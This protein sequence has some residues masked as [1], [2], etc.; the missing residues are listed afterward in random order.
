MSNF[1]INLW[2]FVQAVIAIAIF[3]WGAAR[4]SGT[5][6]SIALAAI[7]LFFLTKL[8][9]ARQFVPFAVAYAVFFPALAGVIFRSRQG[10]MRRSLLITGIICALVVM[11]WFKYPYYSSLLFGDWAF[12]GK[13]SAIDWLGLSYMTFR[14]LDL[15]IHAAQ[16]RT[17]QLNFMQAVSY[18]LFFT[19][20]LA[21]P[22]N[23]YGS[24]VKDSG[25]ELEPI[26]P[27]FL[28]AGVMRACIGIIKIIVVGRF[29]FHY[30]FLGQDID[31]QTVSPADLAIATYCTFLYI[32]VDFSGYC[33]V[34]IVLGR[35]FGIQI[36]E[37][38]NFPFLARN[39]QEFWNRWHISLSHWCRDH[40]FFNL[41]RL[42]AVRLPMLPDL[43]SL[44]FSI[45]VT[46]F[47]VGA[48]HGDA[49]HWILYG[50]Y[51]GAGLSLWMVFSKSMDRLAP[52]IYAG[53]RGN[54]VYQVASAV[55]TFNFVVL[56]IV[57]FLG[58][59]GLAILFGRL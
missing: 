42:L 25:A 58:I 46:F 57:V 27:S 50:V 9:G 36:P 39:L 7:S 30:S 45:F 49:L 59:D 44:A 19:P 2:F 6:R 18:L 33:D 43:A 3:R 32:Y 38:F 16:P 40:I 31:L 5:V 53:L 48:W 11:F 4:Y 35:F 51:H 14:A 34:A 15:L 22:I 23:R 29:L 1:Y 17:K 8:S 21:G 24:F 47:L 10:P 55:I 12:V 41:M 28:Q 37:N 54:L 52:K 13:L 56:G 20:F 26:T